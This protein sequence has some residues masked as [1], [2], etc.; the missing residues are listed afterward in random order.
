[1]LRNVFR[2]AIL[3]LTVSSFCSAQTGGGTKPPVSPKPSTPSSPSSP[4]KPAS[5][6]SSKS[7]AAAAKTNASTETFKMTNDVHIMHDELGGD[8]T[9]EPYKSGQIAYADVTKYLLAL[10]IVDEAG[11]KQDIK[12]KRVTIIHI[13]QWS[14]AAHSGAKFQKWYVFDPSA[15]KYYSYLES[16]QK[17]LSGT[18]IAGR[19]NYRVVYIHL[20]SNFGPDTPILDPKSKKPTGIKDESISPGCIAIPPA[21]SPLQTTNCLIHPVSYTI[22]I[23]K[24]H[25]QFVQDLE[26]VL[27]LVEPGLAGLGGGGGPP[28][29]TGY[30]SVSDFSSQYSTSSLTVTPAMNSTSGTNT[31]G[32]TASTALQAQPG[33]G[34][35]SDTTAINSTS[36]A[37]AG[38][39][40]PADTLRQSQPSAGDQATKVNASA[41]LSPNTYTNQKPAYVGLSF[42]VPVKSYKDATYQSSSQ[43]LVPASITQ[44]NVYVN[45]DAYYPAA[46]PGLVSVRWI[47]HPFAGLPIKGKVLQHTMAGVA[48]GLPWF[49]PF[50]AVVF[51]RENGSIN[52]ASQRT[53]YKGIFGFKVSV[54]SVVTAL[55]K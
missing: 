24:E 35:Q 36:E 53:T 43:T 38:G 16:K 7:A 22:S 51:D 41:Q 27:G 46:L 32:R 13:L 9:Q 5:A 30:W 29:V 21:T 28:T 15:P 40:V 42:A 52:G 39:A 26:S 8:L 4:S 12:D 25:T 45:I 47:P 3:A 37:G 49:E 6:S 44:Q 23:T 10:E 55:K 14:D 17:L 33:A 19:T 2:A 50:G 48:F 20:N 18:N 34:D 11:L 54:S 31:G 1:M